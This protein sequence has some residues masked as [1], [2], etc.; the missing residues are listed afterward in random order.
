MPKKRVEVFAPATVANLGVGFDILGLALQAPGDTIIAEFSE[1]AGIRIVSQTGEGGRLPLDPAKNTAGVAG[2]A[3]LEKLKTPY[4]VN[5]TIHKGLPLA[6]GMGSSAAS[7]V[8]AA[9]AVNALFDAPLSRE[10]LLPCALEGEALVSGYHADNAAPCLLGGITLTLGTSLDRIYK[11]PVPEN[12]FFALVTPAVEVPTAEARAALPQKVDLKTMVYQTGGV[13]MLVDAIYRQDLV[14]MAAAMES[15][16]VIEPSRQHLMPKLQAIRQASKAVGA[17]G[18]VISG[19]GPT[20]C[21]VCDRADTAHQVTL[22]M[23]QIYADAGIG[24][25]TRVTQTDP[26]GAKIIDME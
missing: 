4:G 3:V 26:D 13:A 11:L 20:L 25:I 21:A 5:L 15:D 17:L 16:E 23:Q 14:A 22:A 6:S 2:L 24:C 12:L 19:A 18:L 7:A 10:E 1:E 8:G 9:F